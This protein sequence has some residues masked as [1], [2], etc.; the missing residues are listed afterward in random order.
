LHLP[1]AIPS[2]LGRR[3]IRLEEKGGI[4]TARLLST[5]QGI[6]VL[7]GSVDHHH[8]DIFDFFLSS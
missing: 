1:P 2:A 4:D 3:E 8:Q 6:E 7:G 5:D